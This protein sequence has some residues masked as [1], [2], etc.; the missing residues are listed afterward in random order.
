VKFKNI[1][2]AITSK[3]GRQ[4]L[5]AQKHSPVLMYGAGITCVITSAVLASRATLK[6]DSV[7]EEGEKK[8]KLVDEIAA[9]AE[10]D[11]SIDYTDE[12]VK[13]DR[14]IVRVKT[15]YNVAK[16]YAPA[17]GVG[18][19]GISL[20][21]GSHVVLTRRNA[22]LTAAYATIDKTFREY[23]GRVV[24]ELG[25]EKDAEFYYGLVD[26]EIVEETET[27]PVTKTIKAP[28]K[29]RVSGYAKIFDEFNV[30][31]QKHPMNNQ[32]FIQ[33]QQTYANDLLRSRGHVFLNEVYTMLG[34]D[35]TQE[36]AVVGWLRE[37]PDKSISDAH[38][39]F[40]IFRNEDQGMAFVMDEERSILLDFNVD[41]VIWDKI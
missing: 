3:I 38:I 5:I 9:K 31:W 7:L 12:D 18:I 36:G 1:S 35:H 17:V 25:A 14:A 8:D 6:L 41:G 4:A 32:T 28:A 21:T 2:N 23:R 15:A 39:D 10:T 20:L 24:N 40:G 37:N 26:K 27:G 16:L 22:A 13:K 30:N 11:S 33:V 34:F 29:G 19:A